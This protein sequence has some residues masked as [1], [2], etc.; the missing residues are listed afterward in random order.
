[1]VKNKTHQ[2]G[3]RQE[4]DERRFELKLRLVDVVAEA[5]EV[6]LVLG[7]HF[8]QFL[9]LATDEDYSLANDLGKELQPNFAASAEVQVEQLAHSPSGS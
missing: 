3:T 8:L 7:A 4:C 2:S 9:S 5:H 6:R 1:M